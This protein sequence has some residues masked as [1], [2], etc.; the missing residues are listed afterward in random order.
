MFLKGVS[1]D[2]LLHYSVAFSGRG[3][4]KVRVCVC[5]RGVRVF[6]SALRVLFLDGAK[7]LRERVCWVT[8]SSSDPIMR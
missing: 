7:N 2:S 5:V 1:N 6:L 8:V 4:I 3:V